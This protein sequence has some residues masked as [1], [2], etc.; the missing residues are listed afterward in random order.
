MPE[1]MP[2][3]VTLRVEEKQGSKNARRSGFPLMEDQIL[4]GSVV[5]DHI[6]RL[7]ASSCRQEPLNEDLFC[8]RSANTLIEF[9]SAAPEANR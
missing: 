5:M 6:D 4:M 7:I 8:V 2:R 9:I 3:E 1:Q